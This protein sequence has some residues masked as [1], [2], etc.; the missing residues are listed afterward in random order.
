MIHKRPRNTNSHQDH[1]GFTIVELLV[2]I[3]V[4]GILAAITIVSYAGISQRAVASSII[5]NLDNAAKKLKLYQVQ[6]DSYPTT[7]VANCPT[8]PVNDTK[9]C[10]KA[11]PGE[12]FSYAITPLGSTSP[13]AFRLTAT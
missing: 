8:A 13:R 12:T 5:S 7:L 2:V 11:S 4:I 3:V 6:Y 9:Y 10:L 1:H